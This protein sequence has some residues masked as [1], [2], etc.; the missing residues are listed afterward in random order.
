VIVRR[1]DG[2]WH[3]VGGKERWGQA[4]QR[5][6]P[7]ADVGVICDV[8]WRAAVRGAV[9]VCGDYTTKAPE[10]TTTVLGEGTGSGQ[11]LWERHRQ[12]AGVVGAGGARVVLQ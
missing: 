10:E 8:W 6:V 4:W 7:G 1:A 5:W 12:G 3:G 2:R 9:S 11:F